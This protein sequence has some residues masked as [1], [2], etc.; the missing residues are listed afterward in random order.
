[1]ACYVDPSAHAF[2][3]MKMCHLWADS[4]DEL[5]AMADRIGVQRKWIQG[6]PTL[7]FGKHRNASWAHFDIAMSKRALAVQAGAIETDRYGPLEWQAR[8]RVSSGDERLASIGAKRLEDIA[9]IRAMKEA[10]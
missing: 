7:S 10:E 1:M 9:A 4:D 3:R 8:K 6:H 5:L 2:G